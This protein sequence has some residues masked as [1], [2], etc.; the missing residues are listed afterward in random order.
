MYKLQI[1]NQIWCSGGRGTHKAGSR[2][3]GSNQELSLC[4]RHFTIF[5]IIVGTSIS[6]HMEDQ[7]TRS[8]GSG[9]NNTTA[10][11]LCSKPASQEYVHS[12]AF[13]VPDGRVH[14]EEISLNFRHPRPFPTKKFYVKVR[15][16][17]LR[18]RVNSGAWVIRNR[19]A[20]EGK[21]LVSF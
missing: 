20:S 13:R 4:L 11:C 16:K 5:S 10:S 18:S 3:W 17:S 19:R 12:R 14:P 15:V 7:T 21:F 6:L 2:W 9:I 1:L 8:G